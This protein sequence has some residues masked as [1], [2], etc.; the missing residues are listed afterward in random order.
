MRFQDAEEEF[1]QAALS[2]IMNLLMIS[3]PLS[4]SAITVNIA[5]SF[6][7]RLRLLSISRKLA[8][9]EGKFHF[10]NKE[11]KDKE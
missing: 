4:S 1:L 11:T 8:W 7:Y 5:S 6:F 2:S 3:C 10:T 9:K